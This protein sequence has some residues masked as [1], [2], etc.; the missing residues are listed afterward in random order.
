VEQR[1]PSLSLDAETLREPVCRALG[2]H[3]AEVTAWECR[4]IHKAFNQVTGGLFRVEG[5]ALDRGETLHWSI[6][7]KIARKIDY[8][9]QAIDDPSGVIYWKREPLLYLS[10]L[11]EHLPMGI[12]APH[13]YGVDEPDAD[14]AW[15]WLEDV[16]DDS[17]T[18]WSIERYCQVA[19]QLGAFNGAYMTGRSLPNEPFLSRRQRWP[20]AAGWRSLFP[21]LPAAR[22]LPVARQTWSEPLQRRVQQ[23]TSESDVFY[24]ALDRLPVTF[25]HLDAFRRNVLVRSHLDDPDE[26]VAVDWAFSG[27]G[28][29]GADLA[30]LIGGGVALG[31]IDVDRFAEVAASAFRAYLDGL[32]G[33]GWQGDPRLARLGYAAS[34]ALRYGTYPTWARAVDADGLAVQE[35]GGRPIAEF[36]ARRALIATIFCD[37]ADEARE[38]VQA[39][40]PMR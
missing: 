19:R 39:L 22:E 25:C 12:V 4:S 2:R 16:V 21:Q 11:L 1:S 14:T 20:D 8:L 3:S 24:T 28:P 7:L 31:L 40:D 37:L 27:P 34:C 30:P 23:I 38:L 15:I 13:C 36:L 32:R 29:I 35:V 26:T 9:G 17:E 6:V 10:G 33:C 5:H 18:L